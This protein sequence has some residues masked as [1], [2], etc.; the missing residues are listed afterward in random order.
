MGNIIFFITKEGDKMAQLTKDKMLEIES[1]TNKIT[2]KLDFSQSPSVDIVSLVKADKFE[3]EPSLMP[4]DTTGCLFVNDDPQNMERLIMVNKVFQNPDNEEDVVFKKSRFIT[5]HEYGHY[6]L[7]K[8]SEQPL[9]AHRDSDERDEPQELEA[10]YFARSILMPLDEFKSYYDLLN[11]M[12]SNKK[13]VL[14][15]LSKL[16]N[17]TKNKI[18][19]RIGDLAILSD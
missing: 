4:I 12:D 15:M 1:I 3:V 9:Y 7:H 18:N 17:L 13:F 14:E 10:D 6:I 8:P 19:M 2:S 16:F 5:A 11:S